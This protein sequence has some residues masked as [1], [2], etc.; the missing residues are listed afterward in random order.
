MRLYIYAAAAAAFIA[1][2]GGIYY[3]GYKAGAAKVETQWLQADAQ[4]QE[5]ERKSRLARE[6]ESRRSAALLA[7][8]ERRARDAGELYRR[9][10][11]RAAP[12]AAAAC[13]AT[14]RNVAPQQVDEKT[15]DIPLS[16]GGI[17]FNAAGLGLWDAPWTDQKGEPVFGHP[18]DIA[19]GAVDAA[20]P[21]PTLEDAVDNHAQ[22]AERCSENRRQLVSLIDLIRRLQRQP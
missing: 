3:V 5:N 22:N 8:A 7:D 10:R 16:G 13:P 1:L 17:R 20:A 21:F 6:D 9:E 19:A 18:G 12:I 4:A 11:A 2:I 14:A 15:D